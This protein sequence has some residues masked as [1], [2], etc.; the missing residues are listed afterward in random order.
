M[1][2]SYQ[3]AARTNT[4]ACP[5]RERS[6]PILGEQGVRFT[7]AMRSREAVDAGDPIARRRERQR[8][9]ARKP[10]RVIMAADITADR[11]IRRCRFGA[12]LAY[13]ASASIE[14]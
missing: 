2:Q 11:R 9:V 10:R 6:R 5:L 12:S 3:P 8:G 1:G 4:A 13:S 14:P 7:P